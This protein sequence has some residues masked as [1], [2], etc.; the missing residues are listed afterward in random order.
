MFGDVMQRV[1]AENPVDASVVEVHPVTVEHAE[2]R[3]R[4]G[5]EDGMLLV[6]TATEIDHRLGDVHG[7]D[8]ATHLRQEVARPAT[9]G[10]EIEDLH[11][12]KRRQTTQ[13]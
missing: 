1:E 9:A 2:L 6:A 4:L 10:A 13:Q 12:G 11:A 3:G 7:D 5:P 8:P